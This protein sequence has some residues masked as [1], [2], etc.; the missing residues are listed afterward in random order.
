MFANT[1]DELCEGTGTNVFVVVDGRVFTPPLTSGCLA[2]VTRSLVIEWFGAREATLPIGVL[3]EADE[4]FL[5][6]STRNVHP[7]VR[8]DD[9]VWDMAGPN[10]RDL[11]A[12]F[13]ELAAKRLDP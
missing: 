6:S 9:R 3:A 2:G 5:T 7:V 1:R 4:V 11:Q 13:D 8:V 12:A 10:S